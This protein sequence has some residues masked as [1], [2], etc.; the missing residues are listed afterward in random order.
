M[1]A[2]DIIVESAPSPVGQ[3]TNYAFLNVGSGHLRFLNNDKAQFVVQQ[4]GGNVDVSVNVL[5][6][7][8][9]LQGPKIVSVISSGAN[10]Q[11]TGTGI[12]GSTIRIN[13]ISA[14][15]LLNGT[16]TVTAPLLPGQNLIVQQGLSGELNTSIYLL[17]GGQVELIPPAV[18][19]SAIPNSLGGYDVSGTGPPNSVIVINGQSIT[20]P[21]NGQFNVAGIALVDGINSIM[22]TSAQGVTTIIGS[23]F[24]QAGGGLATPIIATVIIDNPLGGYDV[25]GTGP[26]GLEIE[27]GGVPT[28]IQQDGTFSVIGANLDP[29]ANPILSDG[30]VVGSVYIFPGGNDNL[31]IATSVTLAVPPNMGYAVSG[32]GPAD[33]EISIN[34]A[35]TIIDDQGNFAYLGGVDLEPGFNPITEAATGTIVGSIFLQD[36]EVIT[37]SVIA[38]SV[39]LDDPAGLT[40]TVSGTGPANLPITLGGVDTTI[41]A[42]G[43]F[44]FALNVNLVEGVNNITVTGTTDVVGSV[45]L[46][47]GDVVTQRVTAD[48]IILNVDGTYTVSGTGDLDTN[49]TIG[50]DST[51]IID[52]V[53]TV[54]QAVLIPGINPITATIGGVIVGSVYL[55]EGS[56]SFVT[57]GPITEVPGDG[58]TI[59]ITADR[60]MFVSVAGGAPVELTAGV[61]A[62]VASVDLVAGNNVIN[63]VTDLGVVIGQVG[64]IYLQEG[65]GGSSAIVTAVVDGSAIGTYDVTGTGAPPLTVVNIGGGTGTSAADGSFTVEGA[66]LIAG[67]N[68]ITVVGGEVI[69]SLFVQSG[70]VVDEPVVATS[71]EYVG[72]ADQYQV[73]G[74][75][76]ANLPITINGVNT[77]I[78][79]DGNFSFVAGV[80][81]LQLNDGVNLITA[82]VGGEVVGSIYLAPG[83]VVVE[84]VTA[85]TII[86]NV[87]GTYTV[88]GTGNLDTNLTIGGATGDLANNVFE[89][90]GANLVD[91]INPITATVGGVIL[92]SIFVRSIGDG[93]T[94]AIVTGIVDGSTPGTYDITGVGPAST[95]ILVGGVTVTTEADGSFTAVGTTLAPGVNNIANTGDG[96]IIGSVFL[97]AGGGS[98]GNAI[99]VNVTNSNDGTYN[100]TGTGA[101][102]SVSVSIGGVSAI[103]DASGDFFISPAVLLPGINSITTTVEGVII[104]SMYLQVA[105][106]SGLVVVTSAVPG[107][108]PG[109]YL[110]TGT[111]PGNLAI[112]I[113]EA[114]VTIDPLGTFIVDNVILIN[115]INPITSAEV[116]VGSVFLQPGSSTSVIVTSITTNVE[117]SYTVTGT[118]PAGLSITIGGVPVIID[119]L[120]SF[121]ADEVNLVN[122]INTIVSSLGETVGSFFVQLQDPSLIADLVISNYDNSN[123]AAIVVS[124]TGGPPGGTVS[125]DTVPVTTA[126]VDPTGA[127][128]VTYDSA[129]LTG[130]AQLTFTDTNGTESPPVIIIP[131]GSGPIVPIPP[132]P[133]ATYGAGDPQGHINLTIGGVD[134]VAGNTAQYSVDGGATWNSANLPVSQNLPDGIYP[135]GMVQV[136]QLTSDNVG[137]IPVIPG[138]IISPYGIID[139][140]VV[141]VGTPVTSYLIT[142]ST[143]VG[144]ELTLGNPGPSIDPTAIAD[145][146]G[147]F[148][149]S[150]PAVDIANPGTLYPIRVEVSGMNVEFFNVLIPMPAPIIDYVLSPPSG[151]ILSLVTE[152]PE[153]LT[154]QYSIDGGE[155]WIDVAGTLDSVTLTA[156]GIYSEGSIQVRMVIP[157]LAGAVDYSATARLPPVIIPYTPI[158]EAGIDQIG[159]Y[160]L[161][162]TGDI[163]S[164]ITLPDYPG[165]TTTVDEFGHFTVT[166]S[167]V[168]GASVVVDMNN[169]VTGLSGTTTIVLPGL[170]NTFSIT[171]SQATGYVINGYVGVENAGAPYTESINGDTPLNGNVLPDGMIVASAGPGILSIGDVITYELPPGTVIGSVTVPPD[172]V[173]AVITV[174][175]IVGGVIPPEELINGV[176]VDV[177]LPVGTVPGQIIVITSTDELG[178]EAAFLHT[179]SPVDVAAGGVTVNIPG[180]NFPNGSYTI[181]GG[182]VSILGGLSNPVSFDTESVEIV[183]ASSI[184]GREILEGGLGLNMSGVPAQTYTIAGTLTVGADVLN[185]QS[186]VVDLGTANNHVMLE[187]TDPVAVLDGVNA[188]GQVSLTLTP[189]VGDLITY[190]TEIDIDTLTPALPVL[191]VVT[192]GLPPQSL[193]TMNG[194]AELNSLAVLELPVAIGR[195][196]ALVD[197]N[198]NW[199]I[200]IPLTTL[201]PIPPPLTLNVPLYVVDAAG[202]RSESLIVNLIDYLV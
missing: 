160:T 115:G 198:G 82:T 78:D 43:N 90:I 124:G 83:D 89:V 44:T 174:N 41:G 142:G 116:P 95:S 60:D 110:V 119:S 92:G 23:V 137:G 164:T 107:S 88:S 81:N 79:T 70:G 173:A 121:T 12:P 140:E 178:N 163:G 161:V 172:P 98:G 138:S 93:G 149:M 71:V 54:D 120:G 45:Y 36:G 150:V 75:G 167:A 197:E 42:D 199:L 109:T 144:A 67:V 91:G 158:V 13:G 2:L 180:S 62:N 177:A 171:G 8:V 176:N 66:T 29:G 39:E 154:W 56:D 169:A 80:D 57:V 201:I 193:L 162:G 61:P 166:I 148:T 126:T 1:S 65:G 168:Q 50:G 17:P 21:S 86:L 127:W 104:G 97:Q 183:S 20:I 32:T 194:T 47:P 24:V 106:D 59:I 72:A 186:S 4:V 100:V 48:T 11:I 3:P 128:T 16:F 114:S 105:G 118:G 152:N 31:V 103:S 14:P 30:E 26:S 132:A 37:E 5:N 33:L 123:P 190:T 77:V 38:T 185:L 157:L 64:S 10:Y 69:G 165:A 189:T 200:E 27:I 130:D 182:I 55:Q 155:N 99:V 68:N 122:G 159:M 53:F 96:T 131:V 85:D 133:T 94:S 6:G 7:G 117:G 141:A 63:E 18:V 22:Q 184:V 73:D 87:D 170:L 51:D 111:G 28:T 34:G 52:G 143:A 145:E 40:Y 195:Q 175:G 76:P 15:V 202:N 19:N 74:T 49:I 46:V 136:R 112:V 196:V 25:S 9:P 192:I 146:F 129:S 101:P 35:T 151:V 147:R 191:G 179:I 108:E 135:N 156:E 113:G 181:Q 188:V 102:P 153:S 58:Y 84:R 139:L 187:I 134:T 125:V